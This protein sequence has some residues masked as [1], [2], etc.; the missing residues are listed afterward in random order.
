VTY[1]Y[2]RAPSGDES[3]DGEVA[4]VDEKLTMTSS[5]HN[6]SATTVIVKEFGRLKIS[7]HHESGW[8]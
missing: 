7:T 5:L 2:I 6:R 3:H 8:S 1:P 4:G